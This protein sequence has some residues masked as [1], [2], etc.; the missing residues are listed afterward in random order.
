[1]RGGWG[2]DGLPVD[3]MYAPGVSPESDLPL[4]AHP[5]TRG[6]A[7]GANPVGRSVLLA[8]AEW[9]QRLIH[10]TTWDLGVVA[11]TDSASVWRPAEGSA[12]KWLLDA[13][14]G[15]RLAF[16]AGPTVRVDYASGL[17]DGRRAFFVG[18]SQAF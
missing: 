2:S 11:F 8:N 18:L 7:I 17:V 3:E 12:E 14:V 4:R 16:L 9:R 6:G 15:L 5:L 1:V 10:R 13:G